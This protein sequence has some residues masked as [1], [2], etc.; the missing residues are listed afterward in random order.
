MARVKKKTEVATIKLTPECRLAWEAAATAETRSLSNMFEVA[1]FEYCK[2]HHI[3]PARA[4]QPQATASGA[5]P[6]DQDKGRKA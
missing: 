2:L 5:T 6:I 4:T 3:D 1:I